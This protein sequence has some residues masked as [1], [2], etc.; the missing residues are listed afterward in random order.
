M[1]FEKIE[2]LLTAIAAD[3]EN[4]PTKEVIESEMKRFGFKTVFR[5]TRQLNFALFDESQRL[6]EHSIYTGPDASVWIVQPGIYALIGD[7]GFG[8]NIYT[9]SGFT[10][11]FPYLDPKDFEAVEEGGEIELIAGNWAPSGDI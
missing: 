11:D 2:D 4:V 5:V 7:P 1:S 6:R 9:P 3:G 10:T 8:Q